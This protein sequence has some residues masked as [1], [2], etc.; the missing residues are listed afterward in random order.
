MTSALVML[1][2]LAGVMPFL[3]VAI[4]RQRRFLR[5]E[6]LFPDDVG[7]QF[8]GT[9]TIESVVPVVVTAL[10]TQN[11]IQLSSYP[12]APTGR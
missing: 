10:R 9:L 2:V 7:Q 11:G 12:A 6:E 4:K 8:E 5:F 3:V 1:A